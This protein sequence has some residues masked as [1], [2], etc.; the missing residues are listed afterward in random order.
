MRA[1]GRDNLQEDGRK[2]REEL[3]N[4]RQKKSEKRFPFILTNAG[5]C[6]FFN[7]FIIYHG[8]NISASTELCGLE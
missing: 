3:A 4:G 7:L 1:G 5:S 2:E 8:K 6:S